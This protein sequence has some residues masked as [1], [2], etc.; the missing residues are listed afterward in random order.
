MSLKK[1][2]RWALAGLLVALVYPAW[3]LCDLQLAIREARKELIGITKTGVFEVSEMSLFKH[4]DAYRH[5]K[6]IDRIRPRS[7]RIKE[8]TPFRALDYFAKRDYLHFVGVEIEPAT[9]NLTSFVDFKKEFYSKFTAVLL[10]KA[11]DGN[12]MDTIARCTNVE[13]LTISG[14]SKADSLAALADL[15]KLERLELRDCPRITSLAD[16]KQLT[17]LK[18]I[19]IENCPNLTMD[20][21]ASAKA[22]HPEAEFVVW[23]Y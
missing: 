20:E 14:A 3:R 16:L 8:A 11:G 4:E 1:S 19:V 6:L 9:P 5:R 21:I 7:L 22:D 17:K 15:S 10:L 12:F 13:Y 2:M 18:R 23:D